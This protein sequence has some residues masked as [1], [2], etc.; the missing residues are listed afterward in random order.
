MITLGFIS[1]R[2]LCGL[3]TVCLLCAAVLPAEAADVNGH[4]KEKGI[5][6][7][8]RY[9]EENGLKEGLLSTDTDKNSDAFLDLVYRRFDSGHDDVQLEHSVFNSV[10]YT[11][12]VRVAE[13]YGGIKPTLKALQSLTYKLADMGVDFLAGETGTYEQFVSDEHAVKVDFPFGDDADKLYFNYEG[14]AQWLKGK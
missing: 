3:P 9:L 12:T 2:F 13:A 7:F 14:I 6:S 11:N 4:K 8:D 10:T 1:R 5:D